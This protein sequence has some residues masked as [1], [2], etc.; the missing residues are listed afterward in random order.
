M[1]S[2]FYNPNTQEAEAG[3]LSLRATWI[4]HNKT[5]SQKRE[6][7]KSLHMKILIKKIIYTLKDI[8]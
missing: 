1:V 3:G 8:Y 2:H 5:L 4:T 6:K 7:K